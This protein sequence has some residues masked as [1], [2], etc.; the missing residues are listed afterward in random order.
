MRPR[1][2]VTIRLSGPVP[3]IPTPPRLSSLWVSGELCRG[4]LFLGPGS[5]FGFY[6]GKMSTSRTPGFY[7]FT[8]RTDS[9]VSVNRLDP[10]PG[11]SGRGSGRES[12]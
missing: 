1:L 10:D 8:E 6:R 2:D 12:E 9:G 7:P 11:P 3:P 5:V 4:T